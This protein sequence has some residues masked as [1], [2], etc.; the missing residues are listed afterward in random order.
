MSSAF[1]ETQE[2]RNKDTRESA[3]F[4][5]R[6]R[7]VLDAIDQFDRLGAYKVAGQQW[8]YFIQ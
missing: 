3:I 7:G 4:A 6:S 5:S 1:G 8:T 2:T